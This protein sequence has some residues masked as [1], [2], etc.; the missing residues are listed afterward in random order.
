MPLCGATPGKLLLA[1]FAA[2]VFDAAALLI[3]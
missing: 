1:E 2:I 3:A